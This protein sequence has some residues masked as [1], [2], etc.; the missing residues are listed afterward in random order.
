MTEVRVEVE[1]DEDGTVLLTKSGSFLIYR[2]THNEN[3][4]V[5]L[6][7][8]CAHERRNYRS[9]MRCRLKT[10]GLYLWSM[11]KRTKR[12]KGVRDERRSF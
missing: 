11:W 8:R 5:Y 1:R 3:T 7:P 6:C 2:V 4:V 10:G 9:L 12:E